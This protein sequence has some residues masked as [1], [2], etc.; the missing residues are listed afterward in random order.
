[1]KSKLAAAI[2]LIIASIMAVTMV[3]ASGTPKE[4]ITKDS[5]L[6]PNFSGENN[7][8]YPLNEGETVGIQFSLAADALYVGV[9][10]PSWSNDIGEI[11]VSLYVFDTDY[12]TS[13]S[14]EPIAKHTFVDYQDNSY[15]GFEFT[16]ASPLK[17]GE[18]VMELSEAFDESGSGVGL[19]SHKTYPGQ[20]FYEDGVYNKGLSARMYVEF[21]GETPEVPYG[22]LTP[23]KSDNGEVN[24]DPN[25]FEGALMRFSDP[26]AEFYYTEQDKFGIGDMYIEDGKL[27]VQ[28]MPSHDPQFYILVSDMLEMVP[29]EQYPIMR[30]GLK[31]PEGAPTGAE[32]FFNTTEFGGP[33]AG[34]SVTFNYQDTTEWQDVIVD[35]SSNKNWKGDLLS[36]RFDIL[37]S[38]EDEFLFEIAYILF[39]GTEEAARNFDVSTL[40]EPTPTPE[41][42]A[43]PERTPTPEKTE[44]PSPTETEKETEEGGQNTGM[45]IAIVGVSVLVVAG[46]AVV[47]IAKKKNS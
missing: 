7:S 15:L 6:E 22:N 38:S 36:F 1:M 30:I 18:Y 3:S 23:V 32:I 28:V 42:T 12:A 43:T 26:S 10:C 8:A 37:Q 44:S 35:F 45:I 34:G 21:K 47:F 40:P 16:D 39:F 20:Y 5:E 46:V 17:A 27:F 4:I 33:A 24:T 11:T 31:K 14:K 25:P 9:G 29:C 2:V 41:P 13:V 19:W